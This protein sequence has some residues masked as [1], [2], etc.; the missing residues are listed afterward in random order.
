MNESDDRILSR[1]EF[2]HLANISRTTEWRLKKL[3]DLPP[4]VVRGGK[5][6]GYR[7]SDYIAWLEQHDK[8]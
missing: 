2:R 8:S 7:Y 4:E 6:K 5:P 1:D 3:N